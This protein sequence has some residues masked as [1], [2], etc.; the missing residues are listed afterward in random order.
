MSGST[1][2]VFLHSVDGV[3]GHW[4]DSVGYLYRIGY[5]YWILVWIG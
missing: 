5:L 1:E 3:F 2:F 4:E